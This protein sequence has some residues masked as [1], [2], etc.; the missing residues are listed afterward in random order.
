MIWNRGKRQRTARGRYL[1]VS[2]VIS[3]A[4][5]SWQQW[6]GRR[7]ADKHCV[8]E[9]C[10]VNSW[11]TAEHFNRISR[12]W[13]TDVSS[14]IDGKS[15]HFWIIPLATRGKRRN[16]RRKAENRAPR[17]MPLLWTWQHTHK[18]R[19]NRWRP[20]QRRYRHIL[21][22]HLILRSLRHSEGHPR[23]SRMFE[24][25]QQHFHWLQMTNDVYAFVLE[26]HSSDQ[27]GCQVVHKW[28]LSSSNFEYHL[29]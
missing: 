24:T 7:S 22:W 26:Y 11:L 2:G 19:T 13:A 27:K 23:Q 1:Q 15:F 3:L 6:T 21:G 4:N 8:F 28:Q 20:L 17:L 18:D 16:S 9:S 25:M 29:S 12:S 10:S 5:R 14:Y